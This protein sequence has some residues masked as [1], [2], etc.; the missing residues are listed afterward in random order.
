M[1]INDTS[2]KARDDITMINYAFVDKQLAF[3]L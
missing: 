2:W 1:G 3:S